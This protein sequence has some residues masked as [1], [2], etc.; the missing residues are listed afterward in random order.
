MTNDPISPDTLSRERA[1]T[2][3]ISMLAAMTLAT[4]VALSVLLGGLGAAHPAGTAAQNVTGVRP[5]ACS[6]SDQARQTLGLID[7]GQW[8]PHD[9]SGTKGGTTWSDREGNLPRTG[10]GKAI[11]YREWDVNRKVSGHSRDADR[12]VTGDD[13]SAWYTD[14]HYA[15]FCRMR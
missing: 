8:P 14:D 15:T 10:N 9:G 3:P 5:I 1:W 7:A 12:I 6:I 2:K 13:G 11:R 4:L